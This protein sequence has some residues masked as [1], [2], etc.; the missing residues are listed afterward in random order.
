MGRRP[1][2]HDNHIHASRLRDAGLRATG[3]RLAI[4]AEL[5]R[6]TRHPSAEMLLDTLLDHYPSMSLSTVYATLE[7][8]LQKGL[9]RRIS[10][11]AG[12]LRVDGM[13]VEHDHAVC[14]YCGDVFDIASDTVQRPIAPTE[15]PDGLKVMK[16]HIEYEVIC[17]SCAQSHRLSAN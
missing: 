2:M 17:Q 5:E 9:I 10:G 7:S 1:S 6:D 12:K 14:R 8:F 15:L 4:L 16:I 3:P 11:L 13:L